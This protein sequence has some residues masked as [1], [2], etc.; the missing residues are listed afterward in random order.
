ML[1]LTSYSGQK[2]DMTWEDSL[3]VFH[4]IYS[5]EY[6]KKM[7]IRKE[8]QEYLNKALEDALIDKLKED[9]NDNGDKT[10]TIGL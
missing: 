6:G 5:K 10:F 4:H 8:I 2:F 9:D 1:D 7:K 3:N